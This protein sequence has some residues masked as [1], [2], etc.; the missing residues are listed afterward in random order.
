MG[1]CVERHRVWS[2][3]VVVET[4]LVR[5][6]GRDVRVCRT[7]TVLARTKTPA[8]SGTARV[9]HAV[10]RVPVQYATTGGGC[11]TIFVTRSKYIF[12]ECSRNIP[13][14]PAKKKSAEHPPGYDPKRRYLED[15]FLLIPAFG[16]VNLEG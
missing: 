4:R 5:V 7:C 9:V 15:F 2:M 8:R 1:I 6:D 3:L 14:L 10:A 11:S 13:S 12:P 16:V